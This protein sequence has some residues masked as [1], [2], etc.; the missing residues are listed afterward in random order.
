VEI[1][2]PFNVEIVPSDSYSAILTVDDNIRDQVQVSTQGQ[3]LT[4]RLQNVSF[5]GNNTLKVKIGTPELR[6]LSISGACR[7]TLQDFKSSQDLSMTLSGA[8]S[9]RG[10]VQARNISI[11]PSGACQ[12]GLS[13]AA[14]DIRVNASGASRVEMKDFTVSTAN[15]QMS[16]ACGGELTVTERLDSELSGASWLSYYGNPTLGRT[17]ASGGSG[18][19]HK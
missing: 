19:R 12:V 7:A 14:N 18:L 2:G 16:G 11:D 8:S 1:A 5:M 13:G 10:S 9:L 6:R 4:I 15:V 3:R 17:E